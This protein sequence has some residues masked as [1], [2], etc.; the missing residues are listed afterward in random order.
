ML[1]SIT[2]VALAFSASMLAASLLMGFR[3]K[4]VSSYRMK[5]LNTPPARLGLYLI[6]SLPSYDRML[7]T[8]WVWRMNDFLPRDLRNGIMEDGLDSPRIILHMEKL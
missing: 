6:D 7:F 4:M 1:L 2:Y 8:F 3:N 5:L